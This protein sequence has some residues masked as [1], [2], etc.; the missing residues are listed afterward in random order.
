[1]KEIFEIANRCSTDRTV[2]AAVLTGAGPKSFCAGGDVSGFASQRETVDLLLKEMTAYLHAAISRLAWMD[3]PLI[4]MVNGAAAGAGLSLVSACDLAIA[5]EDAKF[6]SAYTLLGLS[7][8]ASSTYFLPRLIGSRRA[9][10]LFLTNRTLSAHEALSWGLINEVV[11]SDSLKERV[12]TLAAQLSRG[13]TKAYGG[14]KRLVQ[15]SLQDS[16]ESQMEREGR[17]IA[18][19]S[20]SEDGLEGVLAFVERRKAKFVGR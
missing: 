20:R 12:Q 6:S 5:S 2:R 4:A 19:L 3:A 10:E 9:T 7:P 15:M 8:D 11:P 17:Q 14:V 13:P 16:L 18:E 1:M